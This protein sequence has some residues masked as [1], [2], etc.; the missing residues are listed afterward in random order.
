MKP[1]LSRISLSVC[2]V[3][4][5]L[6]T[7]CGGGENE[8]PAE[9]SENVR[10]LESSG[11]V[12]LM[13]ADGTSVTYSF[14]GDAPSIAEGDIIYSSEGNG[15]LRKVKSVVV[16]GNQVVAEVQQ[17]GILFYSDSF[18]KLYHPDFYQTCFHTTEYIRRE[19]SNFFDVSDY[20][21][22]G[23]NDAHDLVVLQKRS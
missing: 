1:L 11:N 2:L 5:L 15:F 12:S 22:Q 13:A 7:S 9:I 18:W 14:E 10:S 20:I 3:G 6:F 8:T 23:I 19:W 16:S 17:Q 4:V 21:E